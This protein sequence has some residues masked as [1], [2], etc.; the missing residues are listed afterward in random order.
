M[1][2]HPVGTGV[3]LTPMG[4]SP[5]WCNIQHPTG[6]GVPP[7]P[8]GTCPHHPQP[9]FRSI[10]RFTHI[11]S[12]SHPTLSPNAHPLTLL[13]QGTLLRKHGKGT[14][15]VNSPWAPCVSSPRGRPR[16]PV[17]AGFVRASSCR[18]VWM[19]RGVVWLCAVLSRS[20]AGWGSAPHLCL[21]VG[22][23]RLCHLY[24]VGGF[25][26][27]QVWGPRRGIPPGAGTGGHKPTPLLGVQ[28]LVG[29]GRCR[30][31]MDLSPHPPQSSLSPRPP[32]SPCRPPSVGARPLSRCSPHHTVLISQSQV[33]RRAVQA[34]PQ[35]LAPMSPCCDP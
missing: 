35:L 11:P 4:T 27:C 2:Q 8:L 22:E 13:L 5:Q 16:G 20:C 14:E 6:T 34:L 12:T 25:V 30:D 10:P 15:K 7:T 23:G 28:G 29:S 1:A 26:G 19:W 17:V 32:C 9:S 31:P 24:P 33:P 21:V 18:A 3:P